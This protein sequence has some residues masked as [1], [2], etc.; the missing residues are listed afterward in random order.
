M[1][2]FEFRDLADT[3]AF[4]IAPESERATV[5]FQLYLLAH[6]GDP[7]SL[8]W[9]AHSPARSQT[10]GY[11]RG[12]ETRTAASPLPSVATTIRLLISTK[13]HPQGRRKSPADLLIEMR[14]T[15]EPRR[16]RAANLGLLFRLQIL[17]R[18]EV[19]L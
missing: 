5:I 18:Q 7:D 3:Q 19:Y 2:L 9:R 6:G 10:P 16:K 12:R 15:D 4:V 11:R 14:D 8:M 17:N 13:G 1:R